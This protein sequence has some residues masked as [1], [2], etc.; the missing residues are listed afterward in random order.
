MIVLKKK[1]A[2]IDVERLNPDPHRIEIVVFGNVA[3][4]I[5]DEALLQG[6]IGVVA[7]R[8]KLWVDVDDAELA[9]A[10]MVEVEDRVEAQFEIGRL[11]GGIALDQRHGHALGLA[12]K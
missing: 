2:K 4:M 11:E 9:D 1:A 3:Q 5:V 12:E 6:G 8:P 7:Y 10:R